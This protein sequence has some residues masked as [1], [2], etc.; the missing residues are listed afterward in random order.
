MVGVLTSWQ[1]VVARQERGGLTGFAVCRGKGLAFYQVVVCA[2]VP[3]EE[4]VAVAGEERVV[5]L[6]QVRAA[7][8]VVPNGA[9][10]EGDDDT[11]AAQ[12][13]PVRAK[14]VVPRGLF[15]ATSAVPRRGSRAAQVVP[16][17]SC[18]WRRTFRL[19]RQRL[20]DVAAQGRASI[21]DCGCARRGACASGG[22]AEGAS[23]GPW[24]SNRWFRR[25]AP[26]GEHQRL[27]LAVVPH[28]RVI[29]SRVRRELV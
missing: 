7:A 10:A 18:C 20:A 11:A 15:R 24:G 19:S 1:G 25:A 14:R 6:A 8:I 27:W 16:R 9:T 21:R 28:D 3:R 13:V 26:R 22:A 12:V 4:V 2:V 17:W 5:L 29:A 23:S